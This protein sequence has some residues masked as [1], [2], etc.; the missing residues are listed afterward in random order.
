[1]FRH[2]GN[3]RTFNHNFRLA[4]FLSFVAGLVNICGVLALGELTTNVTGHFAYLAEGVLNIDNFFGTYFLLYI[5]AFFA[6]S[7]ISSLL[8]EYFIL[9][10]GKTPHS[11]PL[12]LEMLILLLVGMYGAAL[13]DSGFDKRLI[14]ICLLF[15]MGLQNSLVSKVSNSA[16]RTTHLTG[17]FTDLGIELSQLFFFKEKAQRRKLLHSIGLRL[18]IVAFFFTGCIIG[19]SIFI[20]IHFKTL[21]IAS[22][23]LFMTFVYDNILLSFYKIRKNLNSKKSPDHI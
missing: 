12:L 7:F 8:I 17:L 9:K 22:L 10:K 20:K 16:V 13:I 2:K 4:A 18:A 1:M 11:L 15:A 19:G 5:V 3:A 14:A 6:G 21:I 23:I